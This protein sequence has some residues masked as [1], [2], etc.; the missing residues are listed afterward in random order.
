MISL[1]SVDVA[2][3]SRSRSQ[4]EKFL[5]LLKFCVKCIHFVYSFP[6]YKFFNGTFWCISIGLSLGLLWIA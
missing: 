5:S 3:Y 6:Y 4:T 2:A 1:S